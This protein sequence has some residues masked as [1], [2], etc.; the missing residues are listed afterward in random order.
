[1][2]E[3]LVR[4][5][6][7]RFMDACLDNPHL[8]EA[9]IFKYLNGPDATAEGISIVARHPRW[10]GRINLQLA[11]LKNPK[12]PEVWFTLF[13]PH[14]TLNDIKGILA[15]KRIGPSRKTLVRE[16]LQRRGLCY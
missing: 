11:V 4:E 1:V 6:D 10:K 9:A 3:A 14:L 12:T 13:L 15:S 5:G 7:P 8:K 2:V 16:E